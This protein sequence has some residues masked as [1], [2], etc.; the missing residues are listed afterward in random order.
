M[1]MLK[2]CLWHT[3]VTGMYIYIYIYYE[4]MWISGQ[5]HAQAAFTLE[6]EPLVSTD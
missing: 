4:A 2:F 5:L 1:H 3:Y 6:K